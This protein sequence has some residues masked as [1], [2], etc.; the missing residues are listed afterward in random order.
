MLLARHLSRPV[1]QLRDWTES[2]GH[3]DAAAAPPTTIDELAALGSALV[4]ADSRI[5]QLLER[6]RSFSS[7]VAHQLRTPVAAIRVTV[8]AELDTPRDDRVAVLLE[9][10]GALDR[11]ESTISSMLALARHRQPQ[12]ID[13]DVHAAVASQV[14][15][16]LP[17]FA[18]AGR[19]LHC[20]GRPV[21]AKID[22][23]VL[24]HVVDVLLDNAL[25]HG[26]GIVEVRTTADA[27]VV[28]VDVD[29]EGSG[30]DG[31]DPFG[32]GRSDSG[33]GIGLRLARTLA[34]SEGGTLELVATRPTRLR[35]TLPRQPAAD[36][37]RLP[38][39]NPA[40][41]RALTSV[42]AQWGDA[43]DC[44]HPPR[45]DRCGAHRAGHHGLPIRGRRGIRR[46][47]PRLVRSRWS[48]PS[49]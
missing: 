29:D 18:A 16:W 31:P 2:L 43:E 32:A 22:R 1:E 19:S 13:C 6:E 15:L 47:G 45:P 40:F 35:L 10:L 17:R 7:H 48:A 39:V 28:H 20:A 25:V 36:A 26:S 5:R 49:A 4:V 24:V 42:R 46:V 11:L 3:G 8:E 21:P 33:H 14:D 44:A 34:E 9:C 30:A 23:T 27:D 12:R 41:A 37:G 38:G